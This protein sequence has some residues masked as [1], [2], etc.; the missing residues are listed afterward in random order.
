MVPDPGLRLTAAKTHI[1]E[2]C[3]PD[4]AHTVIGSIVQLRHVPFRAAAAAPAQDA[5]HICKL[6]IA[7]PGGGC[8]A[9]GARQGTRRGERRLEPLLTV[10]LHSLAPCGHLDRGLAVPLGLERAARFPL[11]RPFVH[12]RAHREIVNGHIHQQAQRLDVRRP[13]KALGCRPWLSIL[14]RRNNEIGKCFVRHFSKRIP[15]RI[16]KRLDVPDRAGETGPLGIQDPQ[17]QVT[18]CDCFFP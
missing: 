2:A 14:V 6:W 8:E 1:R 4:C 10:K 5:F 17:P 9:A 3:V 11:V 12:A 13:L 16:S 18:R 7:D 15:G